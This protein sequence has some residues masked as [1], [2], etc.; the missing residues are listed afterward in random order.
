MTSNFIAGITAGTIA[1]LILHPADLVKTRLQVQ[2]G[3]LNQDYSGVRHAV[4]EIWKAEGVR[5]FYKGAVPACAANAAA[6]GL[7]LYFYESAKHRIALQA[8]QHVLS[9]ADHM[10]AAFEGGVLTT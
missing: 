6:W 2:D 8:P 5:G 3:R 1:S 9:S 4:K 10:L 7:Y